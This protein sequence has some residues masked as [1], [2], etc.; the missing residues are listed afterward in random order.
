MNGQDHQ[1]LLDLGTVALGGDVAAAKLRIRAYLEEHE[2]KPPPPDVEVDISALNYP[3][4][5]RCDG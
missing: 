5:R 2:T 4:Y 3:E 1:Y